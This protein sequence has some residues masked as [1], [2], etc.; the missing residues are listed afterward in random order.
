MASRSA[1]SDTESYSTQSDS[2]SCSSESTGSSSE[3]E[4]LGYFA[5]RRGGVRGVVCWVRG[6]GHRLWGAGCKMLSLILELRTCQF[7][8]CFAHLVTIH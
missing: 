4:V 7:G 3:S 6:A 5:G 1:V 8:L 2:S